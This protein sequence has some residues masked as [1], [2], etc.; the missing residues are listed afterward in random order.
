LSTPETLF[1]TRGPL[2]TL[3]F[4]RPGAR[5]AMTWG[6]YQALVDA[7]ERV[8]ADRAIRVLIMRG[9]GDKAF[10]AG[11]DI[12]QFE[13]F[14]TDADALAYEKRIDEVLDRLERVTKVT[15]AQLHGV[16]AGGGCM[17]ALTCDVRLATPEAT[18][19]VPIARTLGNCLSGAN[20]SRLVDLVGPAV[21]KD[22]ILSGRFMTAEE[23][24][25]RGL[26]S[27]IEPA[28]RIDQA[29]TEYAERVAA[30]APL[31]LAA[32]KEMLRRIAAGR[33]LPS[34]DGHDLI[35]RCYTSHDFKEGV[36]AFL[37]KRKPKWNGT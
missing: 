16:A 15:I 7:C 34:A 23:A 30:N 11:T 12:S 24:L 28:D 31:T 18:F 13:T 17:I 5:N 29:V 27:Q 22:L 26:V 35:T 36:T 25:A 14:K 1:T 21:T 9:A 3:T 33:R 20:Y 10:I 32:T 19:G 8:D 2:A 37:E 4:N 6:M